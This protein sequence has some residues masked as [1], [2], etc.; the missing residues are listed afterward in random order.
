MSVEEEI[1]RVVQGQLREALEQ[2]DLAAD[3][4][5]QKVQQEAT[6]TVERM[7]QDLDKTSGRQAE[8]MRKDMEKLFVE[9]KDSFVKQ[10]GGKKWFWLK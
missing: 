3:Q 8:S 9:V 10:S 4:C 1:R 2:I 7:K 6:K 5:I